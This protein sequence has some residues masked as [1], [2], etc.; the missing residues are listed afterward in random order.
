MQVGRV[1]ITLMVTWTQGKE[2]VVVV[3]EAI[4]STKIPA[5]WIRLTHAYSGACDY[6]RLIKCGAAIR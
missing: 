2:R 5:T 4:K 1:I 6:A 3:D